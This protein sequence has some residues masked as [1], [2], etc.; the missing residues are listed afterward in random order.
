[1]TILT[2]VEMEHAGTLLTGQAAIP[3]GTGPFPAVLVMHNALGLGTQVREVAGKLAKLGYVA[4]ATDM[5]GGGEAVSSPQEM[6]KAYQAVAKDPALLRSRVRA[7]FDHVAALPQVD[8][9]KIAAIGY[10]FGGSCVLELARSG[11]P[12]KA[13]ASFH[14]ILTST[15]PM[16][17]GAFGG[18]V[19]AFCG[20]H[21]PYAPLEHIEGL[22]TEMAD[23][24]TRCTITTYGFAAHGFTDT[25]SDV[26]GLA[27]VSYDALADRLS[28]AATVE[29]LKAVLDG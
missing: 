8:A 9:G 22:R 11:A 10:C 28:W 24:G 20:A 29:L 12:A 7:W 17:P 6:G 23:A 26:M 1:M 27:G 19:A 15:A 13:V 16:T 25:A 4:V 14:G 3:S 5:Y 18:E 21:D 2:P